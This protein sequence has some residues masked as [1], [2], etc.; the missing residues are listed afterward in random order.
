GRYMDRILETY[1]NLEDPGDVSY[2]E[3]T[4]SNAM[5]RSITT[6][7]G[8]PVPVFP[9]PAIDLDNWGL[10]QNPGY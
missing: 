2:A 10:S 7:T 1:Q 3:R 8:N 4:V 5:S 9:I 6:N